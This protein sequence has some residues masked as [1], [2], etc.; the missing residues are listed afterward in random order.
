VF[1]KGVAFGLFKEGGQLLIYLSLIFI[2]VL[3]FIFTRENRPGFLIKL[4]YGLI[5]GGA[6]SNF[7]DRLMYGYVIDYIDIRIWPIFNLADTSIC[8]GVGLIIFTSF[9]RRNSFLLRGNL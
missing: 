7:G 6:L 8:L 9:R 5:L 3:L 4:S 2:V 1:N